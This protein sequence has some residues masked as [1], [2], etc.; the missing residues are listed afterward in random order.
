MTYPNDCEKETIEAINSYL[1]EV[2]RPLFPV[3]YGRGLRPMTQV[4][5]L[6]NRA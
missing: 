2:S 1:P 4:R 6:A 5:A 3:V